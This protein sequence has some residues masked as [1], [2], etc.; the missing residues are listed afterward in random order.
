MI[1][2]RPEEGQADKPG[3]TDADG[4]TSFGKGGSRQMVF[5]VTDS[6]SDR[7]RY[8]QIC[9]KI[10]GLGCVSNVRARV[11]VTQPSPRI[12]LHICTGMD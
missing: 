5:G 8:V 4:R 9:R 11:R 12:F 1:V 3:R 7:P 6:Q 10:R 2:R